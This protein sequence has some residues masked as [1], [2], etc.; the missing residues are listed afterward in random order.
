MKNLAALV[1]LCSSSVLLFACKKDLPIILPSGFH[2]HVIISC[3]LGENTSTTINVN[4]DGEAN[5]VNC[6]SDRN[7][8]VLRDG[9]KIEL[10]NPPT[11]TQTGDGI[12]TGFEFIVP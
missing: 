6:P 1:L 3:G 5:L 9:K 4:S 7:L 10:S 2:G 8:L 12:I 11:K